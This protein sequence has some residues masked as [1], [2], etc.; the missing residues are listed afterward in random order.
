MG[1]KAQKIIL[2]AYKR[3]LKMERLQKKGFTLEEIG[4]KFGI[5]RQRVFL[6]LRE[7][8]IR[9]DKLRE[10]GILN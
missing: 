5:S 10:R 3:A 9:I 8:K 2:N 7:Q 4:E 1:K 6:I